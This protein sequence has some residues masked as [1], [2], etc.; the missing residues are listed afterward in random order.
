[1]YLYAEFLDRLL[2]TYA[3]DRRNRA[4]ERARRRRLD[5]ATVALLEHLKEKTGEYHYPRVGRLLGKSGG[6][7]KQWYA[8]RKRRQRVRP[9]D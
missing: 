7:L 9:K 5:L 1:M 8:V 4:S 6:A 2:R 3:P